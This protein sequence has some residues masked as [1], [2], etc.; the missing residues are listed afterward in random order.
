MKK[1]AAGLIAAL[2][3]TTMLTPA[4][5][6]GVEEVI[7]TARRVSENIQKVP[8]AITAIS[9]DQMAKR[10]I[11]NDTDLQSAVPGL[12]IHQSGSANQFNYSIRGQSVDTYT[13]SPPAVVVYT[14]EVP[15]KTNGASSLYDLENIQV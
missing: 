9:S 8:I 5:A 2:S 13:N 10:S 6:Q 11:F 15:I 7:V 4:W 3:A 14:N 12:V 1:F